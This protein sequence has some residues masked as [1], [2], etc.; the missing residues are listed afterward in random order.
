[1]S[2][3]IN[4]SAHN[5]VDM[6]VNDDT[7]QPMDYRVAVQFG[8]TPQAPEL[9]SAAEIVGYDMAGLFGMLQRG[10]YEPVLGYGGTKARKIISGITLN[11]SG[12][13]VGGVTVKG[14]QQSNDEY[15]GSVVSASDGAY[16]LSTPYSTAHYVVAYLAGS[17]DTAGTSKNNLTGV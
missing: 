8:M 1:M 7:I 14:Y 4:V 15:I 17:P 3:I 13:A 12:V 6:F 5:S 2:N 10:S 11:S 9:W 16:S